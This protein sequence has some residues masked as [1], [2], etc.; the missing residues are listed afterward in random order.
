[1]IVSL[2]ISNFAL[3]D[4]LEV[5]WPAGLTVLTGE[6]GAGK[7]IFLGAL[8]LVL[9]GRADLSVLKDT[10]KKSVVELDVEV[11]EFWRTWFDE[12][13][14]DYAPLTTIRRELAPGGKSR[15]FINDTPVTLD[16]LNDWMGR[17]IDVHSQRETAFLTHPDFLL[18]LLDGLGT[19]VDRVEL[20]RN[21]YREWSAAK[22]EQSEAINAL[23][24]AQDVDYLQFQFDELVQAGVEAGMYDSLHEQHQLLANASGLKSALDAL[25]FNIEGENGASDLLL[26]SAKVIDASGDTGSESQE[27]SAR[28]RASVEELRDVAREA[29]RKW[30]SVEEDPR[31]LEQLET[32]LAV[33]HRLMSK[34][35]CAQPSE[36][37]DFR[38]QLEEQLEAISG[39]QGNL[40]R[41]AAQ[42][43]LAEEAYRLAADAVHSVRQE[44]A[45]GA[46]NQ[47]LALLHDLNLPHARFE[48]RVERSKVDSERGNTLV[49]LWFSANPGTPLL[50]VRKSASGGERSRV[51]LALK[52]V[53]AQGKGLKTIFFDEIDTGISGSTAS[54][55]AAIFRKMAQSLQVVVITHLP[56]VAAAGS[57]NWRIEKEVSDGT[58]QTR[59]RLLTSEEKVEEVARMV[60]G[61][62]VTL[63]A[64]E[65][66]R[67]L[68][69]VSLQP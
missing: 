2:R 41:L 1:V 32:R 66:A 48:V 50:E 62:T 19:P 67:E 38:L 46:A 42:V 61:A 25:L 63:A 18:D 68:I 20:V 36:L 26:R 14:L 37:V 28:L 56:Q 29:E 40:E 69:F 45:S 52:A 10:S 4:R 12:Q 17:R 49:E 3:I 55:V 57:T 30:S 9:G 53:F 6:T 54:H 15:A 13:G 65:N 34:H 44:I 11:E 43:S 58:T 22:R 27:W 51:M 7:S 59:L 33:W 47:V 64:L 23:Q 35:R 8:Q 16:V 31:L 5:D 21:A 24:G 60:S 39:S